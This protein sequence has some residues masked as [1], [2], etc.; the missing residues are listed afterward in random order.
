MDVSEPTD[1]EL[2]F[3]VLKDTGASDE[4]ATAVLQYDPSVTG[5]LQLQIA[6]KRAEVLQARADEERAEYA[7]SPAG[8]AEAAKAAL[9][10]QAE[11]RELI[12]GARALLEQDGG[13]A[14]GL[15]DERVLHLVGIQPDAQQ[16]TLRERDEAQLELASRWRTLSPLE[17]SQ[18]AMALGIESASVERYVTDFIEGGSGDEAGES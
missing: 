2:A 14:E 11:R 15:S 1:L 7:A 16:M 3:A 4:E 9:Q 6:R 13:S 18:Q 8:R 17:Q 5:R 12:A 10:A